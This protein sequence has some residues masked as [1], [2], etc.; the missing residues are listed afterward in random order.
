MTTMVGTLRFA[1]LNELR[2]NLRLRPNPMRLYVIWSIVIG[3]TALFAPVALYFLR[4]NAAA[5]ITFMLATLIAW[6]FVVG[7]A[8]HLNG[9]VALWLLTTL[10]L[11]AFWPGWMVALFFSCTF[12]TNCI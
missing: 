2:N 5:I 6:A 3:V 10:P 1:H 7:R 11:V 9:R 12:T 8:W 4:Y